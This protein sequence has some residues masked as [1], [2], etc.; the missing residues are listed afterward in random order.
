MTTLEIPYDADAERATLGAILMDRDAIIPIAPALRADD[1]Y[2]ERHA[3]IYAAALACF[4]AA[5]P[6][7]VR[8]VAS[9]LRQRGQLEAVGGLAYLAELVEGVPT[10]YHVQHYAQPVIATAARR[11]LI[12]AGMKKTAELL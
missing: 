1:F 6:P 11:R 5:T 2:L 12:Q 10:A 3:R 4:Q 7:D 8:T 9:A